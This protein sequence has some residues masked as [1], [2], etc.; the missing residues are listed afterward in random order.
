MVAVAAREPGRGPSRSATKH[1]HRQGGG[2]TAYDAL[3]ADPEIDAVYNPRPPTAC[4]REWT[5]KAL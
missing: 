4:T 5:I 3:L 2:T 1:C